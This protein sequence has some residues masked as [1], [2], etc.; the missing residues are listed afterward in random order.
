VGFWPCDDGEALGT[1]GTAPVATTNPVRIYDASGNG[2]HFLM[3][4]G[5][6]PAG[7]QTDVA[8]GFFGAGFIEFVAAATEVDHK[9]IFAAAG[10]L[11]ADLATDTTIFAC[12]FK[13]T[14]SW[15][16]S[17]VFSQG[18]ASNF[19]VEQR[20]T[21]TTVRNRNH[22]STNITSA[23]ATL[24]EWETF[25]QISD[26]LNVRSWLDGVAGGKE[27]WVNNNTA[28]QLT[29]NLNGATAPVNLTQ[30]RNIHT[31]KIPGRVDLNNYASIA[32]MLN[33]NPGEIL[34]AC[35]V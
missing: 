35:Y 23:A 11:L 2:N 32:L 5:G 9:H 6:G 3:S 30:I 15:V 7:T 28:N 13:R 16:N 8:E 33:A 21:S 19:L 4:A 27:A 10:L 26:G 25:V 14:G 29:L 20:T 17:S 1:D 34:P 31:Y 12:Q 22:G 18:G 24:N